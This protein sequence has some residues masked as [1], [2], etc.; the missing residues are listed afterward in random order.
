[1]RFY[2]PEENVISNTIILREGEAR[3]V[4]KVMRL[5]KGD[6]VTAFDGTGREYRGAIREVNLKEVIIDIAKVIEAA[7]DEGMH[8]TLAQAIPKKDTMDYIVQK[9]TELGVEKI[10]PMQT[11]RTIVDLKEGKERRRLERWNAIARE[12]SKQCGRL[13]LPDIERVVDF[14]G[15]VAEIEKN[16][17]ALMPTLG[18]QGENLK[19]VINGFSGSSIICFIGPEG[20]F[21]PDE[22][23]EAEE[24]GVRFVS[25][26]PRV[27]RCDTA[28]IALLS[29][30]QFIQQDGHY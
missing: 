26:G 13:T 18:R 16:E 23:L 2:V 20:D 27:L 6:P 29:A 14:S 9:S 21:T 1:M 17:L 12:S 24:K 11:A 5:K 3:H 10:I 22:I 25:L 8:I 30:I 15:A 7:Q 19:T 28:A 4:R